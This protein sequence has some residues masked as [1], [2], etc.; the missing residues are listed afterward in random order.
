MWMITSGASFKPLRAAA[1]KMMLVKIGS[2]RLIV[3]LISCNFGH[4][5]ID[6]T[7]FRKLWNQYEQNHF[8][9]SFSSFLN[10]YRA[11][12]WQF[13]CITSNQLHAIRSD[14]EITNRK[15]THDSIERTDSFSIIEFISISISFFTK[16]RWWCG[17]RCIGRLP[18][19]AYW[20]CTTSRAQFK[21]S[22]D[23]VS[24]RNILY[25]HNWTFGYAIEFETIVDNWHL[26]E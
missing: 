13:E 23:M 21:Q 19:L 18:I 4:L 22:S 2:R 14:S 12:R 20:I 16:E 9:D 10:W 6:L 11:S 7:C 24:T 8:V 5:S 1:S 17:V 25:Y 15:K 26:S 3:V